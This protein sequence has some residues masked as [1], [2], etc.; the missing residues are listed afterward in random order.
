M[1]FLMQIL[2]FLMPIIDYLSSNNS[3]TFTQ[4]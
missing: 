2:S 1:Q 4:H 3:K